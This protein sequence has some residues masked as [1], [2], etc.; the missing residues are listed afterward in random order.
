MREYG[1]QI[2]KNP[3]YA[4]SFASAV[5]SSIFAAPTD[6]DGVSIE[7]TVKKFRVPMKPQRKNQGKLITTQRTTRISKEMGDDLRPLPSEKEMLYEEPVAPDSDISTEETYETPGEATVP[8]NDEPVD[9]KPVELPTQQYTQQYQSPNYSEQSYQYPMAQTNYYPM[10][11]A[12]QEE[13]ATNFSFLLRRPIL[14]LFSSAA[15]IFVVWSLIKLKNRPV[16]ANR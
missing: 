9:T 6:C 12:K 10:T 11:H 1:E 13:K 16:E 14:A 8:E 3:I 15:I 2:Q 7:K 4:N 5:S